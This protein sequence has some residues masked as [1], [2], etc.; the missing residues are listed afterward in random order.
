MVDEAKTSSTCEHV[1]TPEITPTE[2]ADQGRKNETTPDEKATVPAVLPPDNL[3]LAQVADIGN[4]GL[5]TGLD[6]HPAHVGPPE[7]GIC[8]VRVKFSVRVTVVRTVAARPPLDRTL[9]CAS[10]CKRE[11]VLKWLRRVVRAVCP[12]TVVTRG[13]T[14][15]SP[16]QYMRRHIFK[17]TFDPHQDR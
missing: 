10:T 8:V 6:E 4:T 16:H 11:E 15:S 14:C 1:A 2:V 9:D 12:Q 7:T 5:D 13:D 17:D 3:V